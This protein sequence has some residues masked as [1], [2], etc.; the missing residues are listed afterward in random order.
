MGGIGGEII[1]LGRRSLAVLVCALAAH[2]LAYGSLVPGDG[3]HDYL[4]AYEAVV[5]AVSV[6]ALIAAVDAI[7]VA[8]LRPGSERLRLLGRPPRRPAFGRRP[9]SLASAAF[10]VVILQELLE[11]S[12]SGEAAA[13]GTGALLVMLFAVAAVGAAIALVERLCGAVITA[14]LGRR[15][16]FP[17]LAPVSHALRAPRS[18]RRR[19]VLAGRHGVRA[20]PAFDC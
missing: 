12:L 14:V 10:V 13:L 11:R 6:V 18:A 7:T 19:S 20:P 2:A 5:G 4:R 17:R 1:R 9:A 3:L 16:R 15:T 8:V